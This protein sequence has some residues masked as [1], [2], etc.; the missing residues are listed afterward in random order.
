MTTRYYYDDEHQ[1]VV[2]GTNVG[3]ING[4]TLLRNDKIRIHLNVLPPVSSQFSP[5]LTNKCMSCGL[6]KVSYGIWYTKIDELNKISF[7]IN[8]SQPFDL[9]LLA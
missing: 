2:S 1:P 5:A 4:Y 6:L 8:L 7:K 9:L 3:N